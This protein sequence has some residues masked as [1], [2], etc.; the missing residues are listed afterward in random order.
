[1]QNRLL[2]IY[3]F[4]HHNQEEILIN[5]S[6]YKTVISEEDDHETILNKPTEIN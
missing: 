4:E 3:A 6:W 5:V 1:M 2:D